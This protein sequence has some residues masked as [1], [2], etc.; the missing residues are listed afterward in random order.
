M[1]VNDG[2]FVKLL[3]IV[4]EIRKNPACGAF[5]FVKGMFKVIII[6]GSLNKRIVNPGAVHANPADS[7]GVSLKQLCKIG[8]HIRHLGVINV[9]IFIPRQCF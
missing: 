7:L 9:D 5:L 6:I 8:C 3:H 2:V 4:A 1:T